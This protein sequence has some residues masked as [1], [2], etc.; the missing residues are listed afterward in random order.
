SHFDDSVVVPIRH[1]NSHSITPLFGGASAFGKSPALFDW[2]S[3]H[4]DAPNWCVID[5][6]ELTLLQV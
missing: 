5:F 2:K 1:L 4:F 3:N 6:G